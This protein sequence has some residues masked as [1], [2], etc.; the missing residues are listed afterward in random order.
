MVMPLTRVACWKN[1]KNGRAVLIEIDRIRF[2][3]SHADLATHDTVEKIEAEIRRQASTSA[4]QL[5]AIF[6][7]KNRDGSVAIATGAAPKVWPE[8]ELGEIRG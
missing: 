6:F 8:D 3:I 2:E 4:K 1:A 5:P 7:H